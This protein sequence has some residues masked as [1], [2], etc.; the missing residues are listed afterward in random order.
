[1]QML[2]KLVAI[3][4][5][6]FHTAVA[7]VRQLAGAPFQRTRAADPAVHSEDPTVFH[8]PIFDVIMLIHEDGTLIIIRLDG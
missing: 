8:F 1:M 2:S 7:G 5:S 6:H 4:L 3:K